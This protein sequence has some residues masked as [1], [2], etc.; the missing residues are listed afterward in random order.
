MRTLGSALRL[1][2]R[3]QGSW[4]CERAALFAE[5]DEVASVMTMSTS[6]SRDVERDDAAEYEHQDGDEGLYGRMSLGAQQFTQ[7]GLILPTSAT[8]KQWSGPKS[9]RS[10]RVLKELLPVFSTAFECIL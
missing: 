10:A 6:V 3:G 8:R 5:W 4:G 2:G 7:V 9:Q 1:C